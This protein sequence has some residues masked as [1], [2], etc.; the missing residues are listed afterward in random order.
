[1]TERPYVLLGV[2]ASIDGTTST[3]LL[4]SSNADFYWLTKS[5]PAPPPSWSARTSSAATTPGCSSAQRRD[6][7]R[8]LPE[9]P[10]EVALTSS[11][12]LDPAASFFTRRRDHHRRCPA[13]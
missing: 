2:A 6:A 7:A 8:G 9:N 5:A 12:D 4:L 1:M 10:V 13:R 3:R 11:G